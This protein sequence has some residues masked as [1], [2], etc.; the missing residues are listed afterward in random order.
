MTSV[1]PRDERG[2]V[3]VGGLVL[4]LVIT[5]VGLAIFNLSLSEPRLI[6]ERVTRDQA[7]Y[8]ADAG[9]NI[10]WWDMAKDPSIRFPAVW[11]S[12]VGT[13]IVVAATVT[14]SSGGGGYDRPYKVV[15]CVGSL[16]AN[17][18]SWDQNCDGSVVPLPV[19][20][21]A[22]R[23][24]GSV[25]RQADNKTVQAVAE[26][27]FVR[28]PF[29]A[30]TKSSAN[31]SGGG[32][33]IDSWDSS[34]PNP[35]SCPTP[36]CPYD[37]TNPGTKGDV[38]SQGSVTFS[39]ADTIKGKVTAV[40]NIILSGSNVSGDVWSG[41]STGISG[42][43]GSV[44]GGS[45]TA[46]GSSTANFTGT[47]TV[48]GNATAGGTIDP[49]Q[50]ISGTKSQNVSPPPAAPQSYIFPDV[51]NCNTQNS[52]LDWGQAP[53]GDPNRTSGYPTYNG[54]STAAYVAT[55]LQASN[56]IVCTDTTGK[57]VRAGG[58]TLAACQG[59]SG[60]VVYDESTG[61]FTTPP[62]VTITITSGSPLAV[63]VKSPGTFCFNQ[64]DL[65]L[66]STLAL[67]SSIPKDSPVTIFMTGS[68]APGC[69]S[70]SLNTGSISNPTFDVSR[71]QIYS[72]TSDLTNGITVGGG[73]NAY[74]TIYAPN[75]NV[76]LSGGSSMYGSIVAKNF[77]GTGGSDLH[78]DS[79][80][81]KS[82]NCALCPVVFVRQQ[83][84]WKVTLLP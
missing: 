48:A 29:S 44:I 69:C 38:Y 10:A 13:D 78:M 83:N 31:M 52:P 66:G 7:V 60:Q 79:A 55:K 6:A 35:P 50:I 8:T 23:S 19:D 56:G 53:G 51:S 45:V 30:F 24:R 74:M 26:L 54:Y 77:S 2:S 65:N 46:G 64:V 63:G 14:P 81:A 82:S 43:S 57:F 36:P 20:Q 25:V 76:T 39:S 70:S 18:A 47:G 1:N 37:P 32:G 33:I 21:M 16:P 73:A 11:V 4:V 67:A 68:G 22:V 9:M 59:A 71:L 27:R 5:M 49:T 61:A 34:L 80:I 12:A 84:S 58:A 72:S 40:G 15:K 17:P 42:G 41:G 62:A 28:V 3:L 75:T